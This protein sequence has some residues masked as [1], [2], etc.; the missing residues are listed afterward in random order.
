MW[1]RSELKMKAVAISLLYCVE[2]SLQVNNG[3]TVEQ[4]WLDCHRHDIV[5]CP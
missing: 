3:S 4:D 2:L 1:N 5:L